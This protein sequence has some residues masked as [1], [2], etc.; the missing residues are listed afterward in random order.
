MFKWFWNIFSL[1]APEF[2]QTKSICPKRIR[3]FLSL[4]KANMH[5]K[6]VTAHVESK[7]N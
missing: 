1:G 3:R 5:E 2:S 7:S 4:K 6:T